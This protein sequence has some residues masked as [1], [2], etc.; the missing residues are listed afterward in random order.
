[1]TTATVTRI[2]PPG[3]TLARSSG[4]PVAVG[5]RVEDG[6]VLTMA[7]PDEMIRGF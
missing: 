4:A 7:T 3:S 6:A 5:D 2:H 1:M